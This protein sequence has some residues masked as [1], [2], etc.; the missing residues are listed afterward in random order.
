M[1]FDELACGDRFRYL[2]APWTK[3]SEDVARKHGVASIKLGARGAGYFGD[4]LCSFAPAD[5]VEFVPPYKG[6]KP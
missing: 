5:L 1:R 6:L 2:N 3:L 4:P